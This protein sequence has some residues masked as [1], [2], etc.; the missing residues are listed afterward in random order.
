ML[1]SKLART[2]W[3]PPG[4]IRHRGSLSARVLGDN[5]VPVVLLHGLAGSSTFWGAAYDSLADRAR[6]IAPDLL[7][8]GD[9]PWP[10]SG[11]GPDEHAAAVIS[12]LEELGIR[13]PAI[14][15][16]HSLGA[17]IALRIAVRYPER[18][19]TLVGLAPPIYRNR[20]EAKKRL[21]GYGV[22][23]RLFSAD[24]RFAR[25]MCLWMCDHRRAAAQIAVWLRP[26]LPPAIARDAVRHTWASYSETYRRTI[27][28]AEAASWLPALSV[29]MVL[30]A[31][32]H[33]PL[34]DL[35]FLQEL[36][37]GFP[38]VS[39]R[40]CRGARHD[41]PIAFADYCRGIIASELEPVSA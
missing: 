11:Y 5:G 26:D 13:A 18:V 6:L 32:D 40:I 15:V 25:A 41:L 37:A 16:G 36:A 31:G 38:L 29:P 7:G 24:S 10:A 30:V 9:S 23:E 8:F 2:G 14:L 1:G 34:V 21:S 3:A 27:A 12:C 35:G 39:V 28:A 17:V 19:R 20:S 22:M 4:G 33:D